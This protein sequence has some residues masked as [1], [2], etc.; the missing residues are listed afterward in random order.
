LDAR[1]IVDLAA[2]QAAHLDRVR[3]IDPLLPGPVP[4]PAAGPY[5]VPLAVRVG[6]SAAAGLARRVRPEPGSLALVWSAADEHRLDLRLAGPEPAAALDALLTRWR[7]HVTRHAGLSDADP[8]GGGPAAGDPAGGGPAAGDPAGGGPA[9]ADSAATLTWPSRDT[10]VAAVLL[11]HGLLP[12]TVIAVRPAGRPAVQPAPEGVLVRRARPGDE[13]AVAELRLAEVRYAA[14][15]GL[16]TERP[17]TAEALRALASTEVSLRT[18]WTWVARRRGS[19]VGIVAV[20][21]PEHTGWVAE[22]VRGGPTGY[23]ACLSVDPGQRGTGV[24]A[25]LAAVV[26]RELDQRRVATTLLHYTLFNPL[27]APFWSRQGYRPLWTIWEVRP[28]G[29]LR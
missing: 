13:H 26:H 2:L 29:L 24:G 1:V 8:A 3:Q 5:D 23:L 14:Q 18:P 17:G 12:Q 19:V 6:D 7:E 27:S 20:H 4:L 25:A 15:F 21:P 28:A 16:A 10:A 11:Q 9:L 22:M